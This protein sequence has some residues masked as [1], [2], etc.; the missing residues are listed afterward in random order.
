MKRS[1]RMRS[2]ICLGDATNAGGKVIRCQLAGSHAVHGQ[3]VAVVGDSATCLMHAG[4]FRFVEGH[5]ARKMLGKSIVL[6]GHKLAC[7]CHAIAG[8][9]ACIGVD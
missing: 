9:A 3:T 7:G 4:Q 8:T 2:P 5:P 6:E 1:A